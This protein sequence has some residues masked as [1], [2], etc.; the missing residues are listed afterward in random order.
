MEIAIPELKQNKKSIIH[1]GLMKTF[2][3][4]PLF[5]VSLFINSMHEL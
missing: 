3:T 5:Q 2:I 1:A 4:W